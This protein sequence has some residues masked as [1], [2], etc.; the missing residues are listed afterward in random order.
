MVL[1]EIDVADP[2]A[3]REL[4]ALLT[5]LAPPGDDREWTLDSL[6]WLAPRDE[7][8]A[9]LLTTGDRHALAGWLDGPLIPLGPVAQAL[10][11]PA[12]DPLRTSRL[13][14][15][16]QARAS[17]AGADP[18]P[19]LTALTVA[20]R[21]ALT[22]VAADT[23][24]AQ[25]AWASERRALQAQLDDDDPIA[26]LLDDAAESLIPASIDD[27]AAGG[28]VLAVAALRWRARCDRPPCH[29]VDRTA[30]MAVGVWHEGLVA[31]EASWRV[32]LL[33]GALDGLDV[34]RTR[35]TGR[36]ALVDLVDVLSHTAQPP[37]AAVLAGSELR[38]A[39]WLGLAHALGGQ[40]TSWEELHPM[41]LNHLIEECDQ[42]LA[43]VTDVDSRE[44]ITRIQRRAAKRLERDAE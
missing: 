16:I 13:G 4:T 21:A 40:A 17:A 35:I 12:Y 43:V 20:T 36:R 14:L 5:P 22:E 31:L 10:Q 2:A 41:L 3:P 42:A 39:V 7:L 26:A 11:A 8:R 34:G 18:A 24:H 9:A 1:T 33:K 15:L 28:A 25:A 19:G 37:D 32:I 23:D 30:S 44:T 38:P 6:S 29:G 27:E